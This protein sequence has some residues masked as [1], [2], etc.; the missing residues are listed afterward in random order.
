MN[1][2]VE[3]LIAQLDAKIESIN[4]TRTDPDVIANTIANN[5]QSFVSTIVANFLRSKREEELELAK[6]REIIK[7]PMPIDIVS[8]SPTA[9]GQIAAALEAAGIGKYNLKINQVNQES[10][11][12]S[13]GG[14]LLASIIR[15]VGAVTALT[16]GAIIAF[17]EPM[18]NWVSSLFNRIKA[19]FNKFV[20]LLKLVPGISDVLDFF[21]LGSGNMSSVESSLDELKD[22]QK[23]ANDD[24]MS[25]FTGGD[26]Q[27]DTATSTITQTDDYKQIDQKYKDI[28]GP[29]Q[30]GAPMN[31]MNDF[32]Q[33]TATG[34]SYVDQMIKTADRDNVMADVN[35]AAEQIQTDYN[36]LFN[37]D[38]VEMK[39]L[40]LDQ[41]TTETGITQQFLE[42]NAQ[43][44]TSPMS[45]EQAF[46]TLRRNNDL[47][48]SDISIQYSNNENQLQ[49]VKGVLSTPQGEDYFRTQQ[50]LDQL[51]PDDTESQKQFDMLS[52][53]FSPD[54][55]PAPT[56]SNISN[57]VTPSVPVVEPPTPVE[58]DTSMPIEDDSNPVP[59]SASVDNIQRLIQKIEQDNQIGEESLAMLSAIKDG[60]GKMRSGAPA[61]VAPATTASTDDFS[62]EFIRK[63]FRASPTATV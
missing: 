43:N 56:I 28:Q 17:G 20:N 12:E 47:T 37:A 39:Q 11:S 15:I 1:E 33:N 40:Y 2:Q 50:G 16:L 24:P 8:V 32:L 13:S 48:E 5:L 63:A 30:P 9:A 10:D 22:I 36:T 26:Q 34:Q 52:E 45:S 60:L 54:E 25:L 42:E 27:F 46:E 44:F 23:T 59:Q 31:P 7:E 53:K 58:Q 21:D 14:S 57:M 38:D 61:V 51:I 18:L 49:M 4:A 6:P 62:A 35:N 19:G 3:Q 41:A 55:Q 29:T